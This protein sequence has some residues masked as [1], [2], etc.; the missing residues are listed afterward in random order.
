MEAAQLVSGTEV[1]KYVFCYNHYYPKAC[2]YWSCDRNLRADLAKQ[3]VNLKEKY[4]NFQPGLAIIQVG[5]REDSNVYIRMKMKAAEEIGIKAT[6][7]TL[8]S[9]IHQPEVFLLLEKHYSLKLHG[10]IF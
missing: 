1:A 6:H 7:V 4:P 9:S 5:G 8:P 10:F 3:V 2:L